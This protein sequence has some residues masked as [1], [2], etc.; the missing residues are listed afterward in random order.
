MVEIPLESFVF[1]ARV[2]LQIFFG[3]DVSSNPFF[4]RECFF[5]KCLISNDLTIFWWIYLFRDFFRIICSSFFFL[6]N[7]FLQ[8]FVGKYA[9][10]YFGRHGLLIDIFV[11][12]SLDF[13]VEM[14]I[15]FGFW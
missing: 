10:N 3:R 15:S 6:I 1:L 9:L 7:L 13:L 11:E 5:R 4:G 2:L 8:T 12:I 14:S